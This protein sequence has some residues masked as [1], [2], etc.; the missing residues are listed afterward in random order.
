MNEALREY[1]EARQEWA[2]ATREETTSAVR[3]L[4]A[5]HRFNAAR[6]ALRAEETDLLTAVVQ[7][8]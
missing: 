6:A 1:L 4:A 5:R 7:A 2:Q 8:A 3:A